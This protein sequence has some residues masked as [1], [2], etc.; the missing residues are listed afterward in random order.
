MRWLLFLLPCLLAAQTA[1]PALDGDAAI[2]KALEQI[3]REKR[4]KQLMVQDR[5]EKAAHKKEKTVV[6]TV[7]LYAEFLSKLS[8]VELVAHKENLDS[9]NTSKAV[10]H[11][12]ETAKKERAARP[13]MKKRYDEFLS[14]LSSEQLAAH[15]LAI[16]PIAKIVSDF[17]HAA[18]SNHPEIKNAALVP[19]LKKPIKP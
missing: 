12:I 15:K 9:E 19:D 7:N 18:K 4:V 13:V 1:A 16:D 6:A 17:G 3:R 2:E 11:E 14:T 8:P 10:A 5:L